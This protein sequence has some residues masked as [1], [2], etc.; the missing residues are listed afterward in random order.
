LKTK[1]TA[2][3]YHTWTSKHGRVSGA[4][5]KLVWDSILQAKK[6]G[7]MFYDF[8]GIYDSRWPQKKWKGFTEFK[9]KFGGEVVQFPGSYFRWL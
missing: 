1:D 2:N 5:Y 4:H 3:Y 6:E 9:K 7:L 8:E